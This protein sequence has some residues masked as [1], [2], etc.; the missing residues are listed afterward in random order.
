MAPIVWFAIACGGLAVL[1]GIWA[2]RSILALSAG[3]ERMQEISAA[4]QEG[5]AAY[6][7]RQYRAIA[8]VGVIIAVDSVLPS[9]LD[10]ALGFV[11][12]ACAVR[13]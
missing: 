3:T 4:I 6:L 5:A 2:S 9:G 11:I 7:N 12:G 1:Y 8:I 10:G 13:R